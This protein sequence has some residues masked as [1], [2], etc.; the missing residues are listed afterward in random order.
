M[1]VVFLIRT[2]FAMLACYAMHA[3]QQIHARV[4]YNFPEPR[5][6]HQFHA[7]V[8]SSEH[9]EQA[10]T[11]SFRHRFR[12]P[13]AE[14]KSRKPPLAATR[15]LSPSVHGRQDGIFAPKAKSCIQGSTASTIDHGHPAP[16]THD[17]INA[18]TRQQGQTPL[19]QPTHWA[20]LSSNVPYPSQLLRQCPC[21]PS[22]GCNPCR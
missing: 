9:L 1:P 11:H 3:R 16:A 22:H 12:W 18:S 6:R 10:N 7:D 17:M 2:G 20:I 19:L 4:N 5:L 13:Q 8:A 15:Y 14:S 21:Q